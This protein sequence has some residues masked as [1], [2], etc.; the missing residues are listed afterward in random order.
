MV[1][2]TLQAGVV[3]V[4]LG[5]CAAASANTM[6]LPVETVAGRYAGDFQ[7]GIHR[8]QSVLRRWS[9]AAHR[10]HSPL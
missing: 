2:K 5:L 4:A 7:L 10:A 8:F 3:C 1:L 6:S 9:G